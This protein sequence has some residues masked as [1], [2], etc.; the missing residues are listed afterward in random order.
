MPRE[1]KKSTKEGVRAPKR[2]T[3]LTKQASRIPQ[4]T[5]Y[6]DSQATE[7]E[8]WIE[9]LR[10]YLKNHLQHYLHTT[11]LDIEKNKIF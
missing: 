11:N 2:S 8:N 10:T 1:P 4:P 3:K 6:E 7:D 9:D 5:D